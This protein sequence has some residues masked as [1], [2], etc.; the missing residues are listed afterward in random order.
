MD[1][2]VVP[3]PPIRVGR[4]PNNEHAA[5]RWRILDIAPD[6]ELEDVWALP[7]TGRV[8]DFPRV[9]DAME[10]I[11]MTDGSILTR[12]AWLLATASAAGPVS[13]ASTRGH[14]RRRCRSPVPTARLSPSAS[15][16]TW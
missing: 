14:G 8:D 11:D 12:L 3:R 2:D 13:D 5:E 7:A 9:L 4:I 1:T 10:D 6:F 16:P 15:R